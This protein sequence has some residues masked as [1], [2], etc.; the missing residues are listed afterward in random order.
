MMT[1][2]AVTFLFSF[3]TKPLSLLINQFEDA[4]QVECAAVVTLMIL[5]VNLLMKVAVLWLKKRAEARP[6]SVSDPN[7]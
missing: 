4:A 3:S 6:A 2:S 7:M 5:A 1:I